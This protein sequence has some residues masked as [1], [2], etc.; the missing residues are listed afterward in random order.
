[1]AVFVDRDRCRGCGAC[2]EI[3]PGDLLA[4]VSGVAQLREAGRCW[5]CLSCA[6]ACPHGALAARLPFAL[7]DP[8]CS[9]WPEPAG[10]GLRW[11]C[12][13]ARGRREVYETR[14]GMSS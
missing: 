2:A 10:T 1:M 3:C 4:V 6:K 11:I 8:G 9:L 7:G 14:R 5:N 13:D 12:E